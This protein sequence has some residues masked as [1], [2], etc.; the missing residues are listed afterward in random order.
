MDFSD[1]TSNSERQF[2]DR[3]SLR[4]NIDAKYTGWKFLPTAAVQENNVVANTS[5]ILNHATQCTN[6]G[7]SQSGDD[8]VFRALCGRGDGW[9]SMW[10]DER[11]DVSRCPDCERIV[12]LFVD[13]TVVFDNTSKTGNT[14]F[15]R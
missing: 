3:D 8:I 12:G 7:A 11:T 14:F 9:V 10:L 2:G 4:G 1:A 13:K 6:W 15:R 5:T